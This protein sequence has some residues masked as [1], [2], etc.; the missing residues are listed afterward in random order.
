MIFML[1]ILAGRKYNTA[2]FKLLSPS[3][4][5]MN[6][7]KLRDDPTAKELIH[8]LYPDEIAKARTQGVKEGVKE[9]TS[10]FIHRLNGMLSE[11]QMKQV[12]GENVP[13][14]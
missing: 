7:E 6:I 12:F 4:A 9:A 10:D 8:R 14:T 5:T 11:E 1:A 2:G 13:L 3:I